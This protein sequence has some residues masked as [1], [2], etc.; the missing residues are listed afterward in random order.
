MTTEAAVA[1][2]LDAAGIAP[3]AALFVHAGFRGL[4]RA[5][6]DPDGFVRA[7]AGYMRDGTLLMPAMSWRI[8]TPE[9][10]VFD[11]RTTPGH[12]GVLAERF[13]TTL[14]THRSVHPTHSVAACGREAA[15]ATGTHHLD[16]IPCGPNSPHARLRGRN[17]HML[18]LGCDLAACTAIHHAEET[19][20]PGRYLDDRV[21]TYRR[22]RTTAPG[23]PKY[24]NINEADRP[25]PRRLKEIK[26]KQDRK[27]ADYQAVFKPES[28]VTPDLR[29]AK[30]VIYKD[31]SGRI[32]EE[33]GL[34]VLKVSGSGWFA[35]LL[36]LN[37]SYIALWMVIFTIGVG[38]PFETG[39]GLG[40]GAALLTAFT[41][42]PFLIAQVEALALKGG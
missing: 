13:R 22:E 1:R 15:C 5:G 27:D 17:A 25:L 36:L 31:D 18:M 24:K 12:V 32:M 35:V 20:A 4:A 40:I 3:D 30:S 38:L 10:P 41:T 37:L 19:I 29:K 28:A 33:D 26:V 34:G 7:L 9:S 6:H 14:A 11:A 8:V 39:A 42:M 2:M 16:S 21:E 23:Y